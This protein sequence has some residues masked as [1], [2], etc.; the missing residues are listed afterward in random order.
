MIYILIHNYYFNNS[1]QNYFE[2]YVEYVAKFLDTL[3]KSFFPC[4]IIE[5]N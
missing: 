3:A 4:I 1:K 2:I 5:F